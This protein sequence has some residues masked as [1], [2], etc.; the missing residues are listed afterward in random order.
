MLFSSATFLFVFL[1]AVTLLYYI[2]PARF[3]TA[4]NM[5]LTLVSILFYA[6][7]EPRFVAVEAKQQREGRF[8]F[9]WGSLRQLPK[10]IWEKEA[11]TPPDRWHYVTTRGTRVWHLFLLPPGVADPPGL[12]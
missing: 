6:W 2:I 3:R 9:E 10:A 11:G 4:R 8:Y 7:G 1:P 5:L 12:E